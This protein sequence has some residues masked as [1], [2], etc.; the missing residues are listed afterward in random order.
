MLIK[1]IGKILFE[2]EN[3]TKKHNEQF[4]KK[5][6]LIITNDDLSEYYSWFLK[7]RFDLKFNKP[8]RG[9]HVSFISDKIEDGESLKKFE[10]AKNEFNG[11]DITFFYEI[12]VRT[13]VKHWWLRIHSPEAENIREFAGLNRI[14]FFSFHLTLGYVNDLNLKHSQYI[15]DTIKLFNIIDGEPRKDIN[16]HEIINPGN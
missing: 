1:S 4:W 7:K 13:N 9:T 11:K 15:F 6:A 16:E 2:P 3:V 8:L 14:P 5:T 12:E 10:L